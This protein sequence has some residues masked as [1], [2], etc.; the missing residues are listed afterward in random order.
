[1]T[2]LREH[3]TESWTQPGPWN[4]SDLLPEASEAAVQERLAALESDVQAF[5]GLREE[6]SPEMEPARLV[7][8]LRLYERIV[9]ELHILA[10]YAHLWFSADT[11]SSQALAMRNRMQQWSTQVRNRT[12]FFELWWKGLSDEQAARLL[13]TGPEW[14]DYRHY[15]EELRRFTPFTL[16]ETS[17]RIINVKNANGIQGVLTL[18]TMLTNRLEFPLVVEGQERRLTRS[19]LM[20]YAYSADPDLRAAAYRSL[21][22]VFG[23]EA[24]VLGQIYVNRVRDW[25]AEYVELRGFSSPIAVRNLHN[26]IPDRAVDVLLEVSR[27]HAPLFQRYFQ[28][29]AQWLGM[30]RLRRY[31][32]YAPL[33]RSERT[34]DYREAVRMV[35]ET[36]DQFDP[37]FG[38]LARRVFEERHV[39][40][41]V[42]KGKRGGAF[43]ASLSPR[44][45]P[46]V[47][48]NYT[49]KIRDVATLAHELGHAIHALMS[50]E[51]SILT[52][53][54]S[55]P[56]AET[57]S[58][59][60]EMVMTHRLLEE[61]DDPLARRDLLASALDDI[62]AT[63]MRQAYFVL[64]ERAAHEAIQADASPE[65]LNTLY[66]E[67][68]Q[69][70][71]GDSVEL[72]QEFQYEWV[73]IPH[74]FHTPF[75]CYAYSFGQ[76]LVL[77][78]YRRYQQ[79]GDAFKPGYFKLLAYGGSARPR[80]ILAEAGVDMEDPAFW[81]G[82]YQVIQEMID[83]LAAL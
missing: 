50:A 33:T 14:A 65:A 22:Q 78:L 81:A 44:I 72:S 28:L 24:Q 38:A 55:L 12:L 57:A 71:F 16:D 69:E 60:A 23:Q 64:F 41:E 35:L 76:L 32:L 83:T 80:D 79:E 4:L 49:G 6:L 30:D 17:E 20:A 40:S 48:L 11:Q 25:H 8:I 27:Q 61:E 36:F 66:L 70:Q 31:D 75:Y 10:G 18:Y 63:V 58:V 68:L 21:L 82:G 62:Y 59:F 3:T 1:M 37:R 34:I 56:L 2:V 9:E 5:E 19:E 51:H 74:I 26:D 29:K 67:N 7:E 45:T 54:P 15:L 13:P 73:A 77:S 47:L 39:D 53:H 43:C 46:Y 52:H 42:R